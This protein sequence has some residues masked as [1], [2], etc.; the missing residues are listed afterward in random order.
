MVAVDAPTMVGLLAVSAAGGGARDDLLR[1]VIESGPVVQ[2]VLYLLVFFSIA[3]WGV[4]LY[5]ARQ[6]R[7]ARRTSDRFIEGFW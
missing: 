2:G 5:K 4:I 6:I 3:S 1:M 7:T